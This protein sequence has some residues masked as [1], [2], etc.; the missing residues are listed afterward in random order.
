MAF[1]KKCQYLDV[2]EVDL[3]VVQE[4]ESPERFNKVEHGLEYT[5]FLWYGDSVYKGIGIFSFNDYRVG[6]RKDYNPIY[7]YIVP[8]TLSSTAGT[9]SVYAIWAMPHALDR[10]QS[11]VGQILGAMD[12]YN[13]LD[14]QNVILVGDFNSNAIWNG[15]KKHDNHA[16]LM[17]RLNG[18]EIYSVYHKLYHEE[19]GG[20]SIP[21]QYMYKHEDKPYHLDYC[22]LSQHLYSDLIRMEIGDYNIWKPYSDHMPIT[23]SGIESPGDGQ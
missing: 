2:S 15:A 4:C 13:D 20:E 8:L 6:I 22:C 1:R 16:D 23:I 3:L 17:N 18:S 21:T 12:Y 9:Y 5:D 19:Q 10:K 11:Y 7:R 14:A